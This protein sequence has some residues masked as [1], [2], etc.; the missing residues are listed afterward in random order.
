MRMHLRDFGLFCEKYDKRGR[1]RIL[2]RFKLQ[3][4]MEMYL[5]HY[6]AD[7]SPKYF[8]VHLCLD[9]SGDVSP[10]YFNFHLCLD[11]SGDASP[12]YFNVHL[13]LDAFEDVSP[14]SMDI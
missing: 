9:A 11:A 8:S 7:A 10:K 5:R 2:A 14:E 6:S 13:C 4:V 3:I 1:E 12:K